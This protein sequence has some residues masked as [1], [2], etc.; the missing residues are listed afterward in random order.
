MGPRDVNNDRFLGGCLGEL[1]GLIGE[2]SVWSRFL[3]AR[4]REGLVGKGCF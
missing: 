2:R 3:A 1:E 4:M